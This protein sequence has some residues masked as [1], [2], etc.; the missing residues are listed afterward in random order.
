MNK[1]FLYL[2]LFVFLFNLGLGFVHADTVA[3]YFDS[4]QE[5]CDWQDYAG[6]DLDTTHFNNVQGSISFAPGGYGDDAKVCTSLVLDDVTAPLY[7]YGVTGDSSASDADNARIVFKTDAPSTYS[8]AMPT[9]IRTL[10]DNSGQVID[11]LRVMKIDITTAF[12]GTIP[13]SSI[14]ACF[15]SSSASNGDYAIAFLSSADITSSDLDGMNF[16]EVQEYFKSFSSFISPVLPN[17]I[18]SVNSPSFNQSFDTIEPLLS[19]TYADKEGNWDTLLAE[20][21]NV[22]DSVS[23][24]SIASWQFG[25]QK[26]TSRLLSVYAIED[27]ID[28]PLSLDKDYTVRFNLVN[29]ADLSDTSGWTDLVSFDTFGNGLGTGD[30]AVIGGLVTPT[31]TTPPDC[32]FDSLT[33]SIKCIGEH[34]KWIFLGSKSFSDVAN[35]FVSFVSSSWENG[36]IGATRNLFSSVAEAFNSLLEAPSVADSVV[37]FYRSLH[38]E[39]VK[40][41]NIFTIY[42]QS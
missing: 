5:T 18:L 39:P 21:N 13:N 31:L 23:A 29:S 37:S 40:Y 10:P 26:T 24:E 4:T 9:L 32:Q 16:V 11:E 25:A 20:F 17:G 33:N 42:A 7:M 22:T 27:F 3:C 1:N 12:G 34:F 35:S 6:T 15:D 30:S 38:C 28:V 36:L 2:I 41:I 14:T 19:V 8:P